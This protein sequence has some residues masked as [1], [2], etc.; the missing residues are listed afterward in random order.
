MN[1]WKLSVNYVKKEKLLGASVLGNSYSLVS[2]ISRK[3]IKFSQ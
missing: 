3:L 2:F 1:L